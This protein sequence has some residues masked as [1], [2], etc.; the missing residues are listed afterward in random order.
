MPDLSDAL[1]ALI[2]LQGVILCIAGTFY[3]FVLA[4][5]A[6]KVAVTHTRRI[7]IYLGL[8]MWGIGLS[9]ISTGWARGLIRYLEDGGSVALGQAILV[10]RLITVCLMAVALIDTAAAWRAARRRMND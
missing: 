7:I 10:L 6:P 9:E 1:S 5:D 8:C 3:L 2:W 4:F